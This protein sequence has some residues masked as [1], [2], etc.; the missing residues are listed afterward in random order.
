MV[1]TGSGGMWNANR[2][3][4]EW[5]FTSPEWNS[6]EIPIEAGAAKHQR[7][8]VDFTDRWRRLRA[9]EK[10]SMRKVKEVLR[11]RFGLGLQTELDRRSCSIGQATKNCCFRSRPA[12]PIGPLPG[13]CRVRRQLRA[14]K[15]LTLQLV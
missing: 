1:N 2:P 11:L 4:P 9:Q 15:H 5:L 6:E 12:R 14:H 8:E 3:G 7:G 10:V 13:F